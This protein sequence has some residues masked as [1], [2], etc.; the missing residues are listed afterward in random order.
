[1]HELLSQRL[2][3]ILEAD[4]QTGGLTLNQLLLRTEGR[5]LYLVT[6][7]L[8]LPFVIPVPLP[9][10]S[11]VVGGVIAL[12]ALRLALGL[13]ARL[14]RFIGERPLPPNLQRMVLSGS[15]KLLRWIEKLAKPRRTQWLS[16]PAARAGNALLILFL[17]LLLA[18]PLP[19]VLPLSNSLPALAIILVAISMMEEDGVMIWIGYLASLVTAAWLGVSAGLIITFL[20]KLHHALMQYLQAKP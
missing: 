4:G 18:L 14:P 2:A 5:G 6:I 9:G 8:S 16:W 17:G 15:V 1:M 3:R 12:L 11:T 20:H 7:V 13:R 19:P 10:F